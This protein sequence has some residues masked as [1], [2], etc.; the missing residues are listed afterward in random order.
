MSSA[1][2]VATPRYSASVDDC[3]TVRC[4]RD[5]Q[6]IGLPPKKIRYADVEVRSSIFPPQSASVKARRLNEDG[7]FKIMP[8]LIVP[9]M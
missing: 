6:E 5:S 3:A 1:V 9:L 4:F 8:K 2:A 7:F